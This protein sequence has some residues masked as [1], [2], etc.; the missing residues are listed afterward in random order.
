MTSF[1]PLYAHPTSG[2][3]SHSASRVASKPEH[4]QSRLEQEDECSR[5]TVAK[6]KHKLNLRIN[7]L[8]IHGE[9]GI[10]LCQNI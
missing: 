4:T 6:K 3:F 7:T 2:P 8:L 5:E 9:S 1:L 10:Q